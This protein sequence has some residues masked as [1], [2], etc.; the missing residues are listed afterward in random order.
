MMSPAVR[1]AFVLAGTV[2]Y[3]GLA[4]LGA[5]GLALF[6]DHSALIALAAVQVALSVVAFFAG[7]NVSSGIK[8]DR[9]NRWVLPVFV[10]IGLLQAYLPAWTDRHEIW[11]LDG[12]PL[13]WVGVLLFAIGGVLR[14]WPVFVLGD[15]F[16]GLVAIQPHHTLVTAGP[17]RVI[18]HPSYLGLMVIALG[19]SLAFRSA[20]GVGLTAMLVPAV[21]ARI[22]AEERLLQ[23]EFGAEY[24][25]FRARTSRLLPGIY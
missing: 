25:A 18:R 23:A 15:R 6:I 22:A 12:D 2:G 8:E 1:L 10:V 17:Y 7:G 21:L 24:D 4:V 14:L 5:G 3:L 16:S 9:S 20:V 19:W 11:C 13:R